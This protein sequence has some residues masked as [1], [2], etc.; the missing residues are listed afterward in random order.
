MQIDEFLQGSVVVV[1]VLASRI[2]GR[3]APLKVAIANAA[4]RARAAVVLEL[5]AVD[6]V[7]SAGLGILLGALK[8][9]KQANKELYLCGVNPATA[10]LLRLTRTEQLFTIAPDLKTAVA[11]ST[12]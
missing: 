8:E 10:A 4:K 11:Q 6:I 1:R 2:D 12:R 9:A 3:S 7:D 5:G